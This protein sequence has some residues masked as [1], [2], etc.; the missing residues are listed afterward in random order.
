MVIVSGMEDCVGDAGAKDED[1][2]I[3]AEANEEAALK[4]R[5]GLL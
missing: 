4:D 3:D 1:G 5:L 2:A